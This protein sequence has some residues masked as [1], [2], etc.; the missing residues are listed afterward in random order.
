M[1]SNHGNRTQPNKDFKVFKNHRVNDHLITFLLSMV[2][3]IH[4]SD[5]VDSP[6]RVTRKVTWVTFRLTANR[7]PETYS[8]NTG[9]GMLLIHFLYLILEWRWY[10]T[11]ALFSTTQILTALFNLFIIDMREDLGCGRAKM[12]LML[13]NEAAMQSKLLYREYKPARWSVT[14]V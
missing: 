11:K 13:D 5:H 8:P 1:D 4:G 14:S 12:T 7:H 3:A 2:S 9:T 10:W 6:F